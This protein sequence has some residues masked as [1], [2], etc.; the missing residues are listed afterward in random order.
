[1]FREEGTSLSEVLVVI[2]LMVIAGAVIYPAFIKQHQARNNQTAKETLSYAYDAAQEYYEGED[3]PCVDS[4]WSYFD[5]PHNN[6]PD[7]FVV[8]SGYPLRAKVATPELEW[9]NATG[10]TDDESGSCTAEPYPASSTAPSDP[11]PSK[12][13]NPK[14]IT[15]YKAD[16]QELVLC[17]AGADFIYCVTNNGPKFGVGRS[18]AEAYN[19]IALAEPLTIPGG[20]CNRTIGKAELFYTQNRSSC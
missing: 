1:M 10:N 9:V 12:D 7:S 18:Q 13:S 11:V 4:S 16:S 8:S 17:N 14:K 15:I 3:N 5:R 2:A 6:P 20:P 19:N